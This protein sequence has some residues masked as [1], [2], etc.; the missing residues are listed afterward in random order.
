MGHEGRCKK[1]RIRICKLGLYLGVVVFG[2]YLMFLRVV[3]DLVRNTA[4]V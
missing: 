1:R 4:F 3:E 2:R